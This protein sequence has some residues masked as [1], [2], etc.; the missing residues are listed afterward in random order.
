MLLIY[1]SVFSVWVSPRWPRKTRR[2]LVWTVNGLNNP[3]KHRAIFYLLRAEKCDDI[4]LQETHSIEK[5]HKIWKSEW[6]GDMI[7]AHGTSH[8]RG[9]VILIHRDVNLKINSITRV[10]NGRFLI[11]QIDHNNVK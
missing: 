5:T 7:A 11:L 6:G 4:L 9:V 8:D 10:K 1:I 2:W 3:K